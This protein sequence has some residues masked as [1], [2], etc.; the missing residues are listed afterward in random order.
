M[1]N[2]LSISKFDLL[3]HCLHPTPPLSTQR[4]LRIQS[5][6]NSSLTA[7]LMAYIHYLG[8]KAFTVFVRLL[9]S[10]YSW[11]VQLVKTP[12]YKLYPPSSIYYIPSSK[13]KERKI[14]IHQ[15]S[16]PQ[17][18]FHS[19]PRHCANGYWPLI[20][21]AAAFCVPALGNEADYCQHLAQK[22]GITVLDCDYAKAPEY[23][24]LHA[25]ADAQD[26]LG[27]VFSAGHD[28]FDL[29]RVTIGGCSSGATLALC[30]AATA[31][32]TRETSPLLAVISSHSVTNFTIE[33]AQR[34]GSAEPAPDGLGLNF[35]PHMARII[36][37]SFLSQIPPEIPLNDPRV[38]PVFA[39][40]RRYP[41]TMVFITSEHDILRRDSEEMADKLR[42]AGLTEDL[43]VYKA[44]GVGH[45]FETLPR[46]PDSLLVLR[47]D[48]AYRTVVD[49]LRR[50]YNR[51]GAWE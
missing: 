41:K 3:D 40:P 38:S 37:G 17:P 26:V 7:A 42:G 51:V 47:T 6:T 9:S 35:P 34:F 11:L 18:M 28:R 49:A 44:A 19:R 20:S 13:D 43:V 50:A 45:I 29:T 46:N 30:T 23:S 39:D 25:L 33:T 36:L 21:V 1:D 31:F 4:Q 12:K 2:L 22:L 32:P 24:W 16:P 27:H 8:Y 15:Y 10:D 5:A 48:E 14:R